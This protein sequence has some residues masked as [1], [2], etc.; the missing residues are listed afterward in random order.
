MSE[1]ITRAISGIVVVASI[2]CC[3]LLS[4]MLYALLMLVVVAVGTFELCRMKKINNRVCLAM[5]EFVVLLIYI[6]FAGYA[7]G[8][9]GT[10]VLW[11]LPPVALVPFLLALFSVKCTFE[12]LAS[13]FYAAMF[14]L[15]MPSVLMLLMYRSDFVGE[16]NG[17]VLL[18]V[19][20]VTI[21]TN[22][23]FAYLVGSLLGRHKL[24]ARISPG[25]TIE[26]SLGGLAATVAAMCVYSHF[27]SE[28]S[29]TKAMVI[30]AIGIVAGTLGDL[31]ESMLKR[32]AGVKDSG[33]LIPG[34][35]GILD[36]FDSVMF[37]TTFIFTYLVLVK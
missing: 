21:W 28:L 7:L 33:K 1:L 27:N 24:F 22:D 34:H 6:I 11:F 37:A 29:C 30:A 20:Y 17:P 5:T 16:F 31:V 8:Y 4:P 3:I 10:E 18:V 32:Q 9:L 35:G 36:R 2:V 19:L 23:I 25:K 15:V 13:T 12:S 14:C 26:G